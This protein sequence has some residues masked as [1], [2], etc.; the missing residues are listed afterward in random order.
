M[1]HEHLTNHFNEKLNAKIF[2]T[3]T[4]LFSNVHIDSIQET[5][6]KSM[7]MIKLSQNMWKKQT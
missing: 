5:Y 2:D 4:D 3:F 1:E 7:Y 6:P